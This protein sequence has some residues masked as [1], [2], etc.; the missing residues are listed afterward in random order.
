MTTITEKQ[1]DE[2]NKY[3]QWDSGLEDLIV[4]ESTKQKIKSDLN[5]AMMGRGP[6]QGYPIPDEE[7][8]VKFYRNSIKV[9]APVIAN[10]IAQK[11]H[12]VICEDLKY[13]EKREN[14]KDEGATLAIAVAD[15]L[16]MAAIALPVPLTA[17]SVYLVKKGILD[18]ICDCEK[19]DS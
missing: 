12:K 15:G 19:T 4:T 18:N 5:D 11:A 16:L 10:E 14:L 1:I 8:W 6:G 7:T 9:H 3:W 13:C 2:I 17:I